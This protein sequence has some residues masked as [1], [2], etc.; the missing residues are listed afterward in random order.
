[1]L[2]ILFS[3][4]SKNQ[5]VHIVPRWN[6]KLLSRTSIQVLWRTGTKQHTR[7]DHLLHL[8]LFSIKHHSSDEDACVFKPGPRSGFVQ[9]NKHPIISVN[10][11]QTCLGGVKR[12]VHQLA[13]SD[14]C[15]SEVRIQTASEICSRSRIRGASPKALHWRRPS[16]LFLHSLLSGT[17]GKNLGSTRG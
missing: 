15:T 9:A 1:M 3:S 7:T 6:T 4:V 14:P 5:D 17:E 8:G 16:S 2:K 10:Y 11:Y 12:L 13:G